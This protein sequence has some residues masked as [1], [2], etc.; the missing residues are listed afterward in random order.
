M[1]LIFLGPPGAGKGTT[2][3]DLKNRLAIPHI[4]TGDLFREQ[5]KNETD[6]GKEVKKIIEAGNLVPDSLTIE[7]VRLRLA[8]SDA[9]KGYILDGFPRTLPQAEALHT[10]TSIDAVINLQL[11]D[12]IIIERLS[13]RRLCPQCGA[14]YHLR[15]MPPKVD[16]KCDACGGALITRKDDQPD[17]IQNRLRVYA[18]STR[19][20]IDFYAQKGLLVD[21]DTNRPAAEVTDAVEAYC[22]QLK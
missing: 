14:G 4:S 6:L 12:D 21:F 7:M 16:G 1:N 9:Q 3:A 5:M 15:F 2:A 19:P 22:R 13:G 18:Q 8:Q 11:A 10:F 20:L 17:S